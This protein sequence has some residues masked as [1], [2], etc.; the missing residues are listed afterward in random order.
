MLRDALTRGLGVGWTSVT[1]GIAEVEGVPGEVV[2]AFSRRRAQIEE[3]LAIRGTTGPRAAEAAALATREKKEGVDG[4]TLF[5]DWRARA[6]EF[7]WTADRLDMARTLPPV[8]PTDLRRVIDALIGAE[9]LTRQAHATRRDVVRA[10]A[11]MIEP[12]AGVTATRLLELADEILTDDR[13]VALVDSPGGELFRCRDGRSLPADPSQREFSTREIIA[14]ERQILETAAAA[15]DGDAGVVGDHEIAAAIGRRPTL[16][17]E[18]R[19]LVGTLTGRGDAIAV[20]TGRAGS[21]KTFALAAAHEAWVAGGHEVLGAA[22]ARRAARELEHCA[23]IPSTSVAALRRRLEGAESLPLRTVLVIDEASM[24]GTRD[25][26]S[27]VAV[28]Q[29][30]DGKLVLVGDAGQLPSISAGGAFAALA[31]TSSAIE[32]RE[33]RRQVEAWERTAV[34]L[35]REGR[36]L[37]A[38]A[39]YDAHD[40][41]HV[42][43]TSDDARERMVG[44]WRAAV[45]DTVMIAARRV[46]VEDL[47][48][49]ARSAARA[50]G[51]LGPDEFTVHGR[52][53]AVGDRVVLKRNDARL[54]A[55]NGDRGTVVSVVRGGMTV[56]TAHA[57]VE[58]D[59]IYLSAVGEPSVLHGYAMT[60]HVAQGA[61]VDRSFV[62]ADAGLCREWGYTALTRGRFENRLYLSR[63]RAIDRDEY[64]PRGEFSAGDPLA[65]L[66]N[67]LDQSEAESLALDRGLS[68]SRGRQL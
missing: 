58:L 35:L 22:V 66:A 53:F 42:A 51:E 57:D 36:S 54:G 52:L 48:A 23:G 31:R 64:G 37:E 10:L 1:K 65:R 12:G 61:T 34:D 21:G 47:N 29:V 13:V 67:S 6:E 59:R 30:R 15:R 3:A 39:M 16:S 60:C 38:V 63:D 5:T 11:E 24:L 40:R 43:A 33:N 18:Q 44:D 46:D 55:I 41:I 7:N 68:R 27:L 8:E 28:V 4:R 20:V 14:L 2:R 50:L 62:L 17:Q 45:G 26:A 56:R 9:G 25:L 19:N 32:L 49:R